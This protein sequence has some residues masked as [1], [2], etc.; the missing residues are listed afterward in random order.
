MRIGF[1]VAILVYL[2][3]PTLMFSQTGPDPALIEAAKKEGEMVYYTTMT[4]SQSKKVVDKFEKKYPFIKVDL[5]RTGGGPLLNKIQTE[6][7]GGRYAW[8]VVSGRGEMVLPLMNA[9][10]LAP[11]RSPESKT[12]EEDLVDNESYWTAYY[13]NPYVLG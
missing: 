4:I 1:I 12:I 7:R 13:V 5:F 10:F 2:V 9:K 11:Y 6:A 3:C 8:D